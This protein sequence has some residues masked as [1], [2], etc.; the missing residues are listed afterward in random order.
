MIY[1][2]QLDLIIKNCYFN[3]I[4]IFLFVI[5]TCSTIFFVSAHKIVQEFNSKNLHKKEK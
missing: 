1:F 4:Y 5:L 3:V 2:T